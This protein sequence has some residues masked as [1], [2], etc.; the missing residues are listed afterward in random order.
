MANK[1]EAEMVNAVIT[2]YRKV[3]AKSRI[4]R[5]LEIDRGAAHTDDRRKF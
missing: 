1:L 4:A 3:W 2:L 5:E